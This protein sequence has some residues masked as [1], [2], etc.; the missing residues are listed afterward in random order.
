MKTRTQTTRKRWV[1]VPAGSEPIF[2]G[3]R[4]GHGRLVKGEWHITL[5]ERLA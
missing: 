1:T 2:F 4:L 5:P 3:G